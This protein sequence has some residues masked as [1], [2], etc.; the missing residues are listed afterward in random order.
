MEFIV[1][2]PLMERRHDLIFLV[3]DTVMKSAYFI[4]MRMMY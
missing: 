2:F 4:P 1:G 3:V